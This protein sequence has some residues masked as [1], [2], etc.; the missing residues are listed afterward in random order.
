MRKNLF[1]Q[2]FHRSRFLAVLVLL[3]ALPLSLGAQSQKRTDPLELLKLGNKRF[4]DDTHFKG[5][6]DRAYRENPQTPYA[7]I[8][9]CSDSRVPPELV[10]GEWQSLGKLFVI[11]TAGNVVD[12]VALG[13][14]E[15]AAATL[16]AKLILVLGHEKCG[17]VEAARARATT[18]L[19]PNVAW[20][21]DPIMLAVERTP[22]QGPETATIKENVFV[23]IENLR[24]QSSIIRDLEA[25][26]E[27]SIAGGF[28]N[29]SSVEKTGVVDF[30][31]EAGSRRKK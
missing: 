10:F 16:K 22:V 25:R 14:I 3:I 20:F 26:R 30:I 9:S 1:S 28:Y 4:V 6:R 18:P 27:L 21:V 12:P 7:V 17:A 24:N 5:V 2:F 29:I 8:L 15:Y 19:S 31:Y 23:Q 13:S 11:R